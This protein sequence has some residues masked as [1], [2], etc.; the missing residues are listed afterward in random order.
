MKHVLVSFLS[1]LGRFASVFDWNGYGTITNV[2]EEKMEGLSSEKK[3][4]I[5]VDRCFMQCC[6]MDE[7]VES[8]CVKSVGS[9]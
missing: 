4:W 1:Y 8:V 2:R 6:V 7:R 5:L 9:V 3:K